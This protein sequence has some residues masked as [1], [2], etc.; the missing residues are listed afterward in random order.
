MKNINKNE[1]SKEKDTSNEE[2]SIE[3]QKIVEEKDSEQQPNKKEKINKT[4]KKVFLCI[5]VL[6]ILFFLSI[7][8]ILAVK[9]IKID[10][11]PNKYLYIFI[12]I[13]AFFNII[14]SL[15]LLAKKIWTKIISIILYI[16]LAIISFFGIKYIS[17]TDSFLDEAFD[18]YTNETSTYYVIVKED[19]NY[20]SL[21]DLTDKEMIYFTFYNDSEKI[22]DLM[23]EKNSNIKLVEYDN[24]S[25]GI[26]DFLG[27]KVASVVIDIGHL[28]IV[29]E[30]FDGFEDKIRVIDTFDITTEIQI[31]DR[32][33]ATPE[34]DE[35]N[36]EKP[37]SNNNNEKPNENKPDNSF[38]TSINKGNSLN[39]Y[40]SGSDSRTYEVYN[41][42][43]TD[44]N[45]VL[46][47][48]P[49]TKTILVTSI[50]RDYYVQ[51]AGTTGSKDK[52]SYTGLYGLNNSTAVIAELFNIDIDY[53]IKLGF[54]AV[55]ELVDLVGGI[56]INSR[57]AFDSSHLKGWHVQQGINHMDGKKALAY[58]RE[59]YAYNMG[60]KDRVLNQQQVFEET[61]KK[62]MSN[63]SI[64]LKYEELL[65]SLK[66]FYIT[67]IPRSVISEYIKLQL[68]DMS[69]WK[70]IKQTIDGEYT[71]STSYTLPDENVIVMERNQA[72]INKARR[73]IKEVLEAR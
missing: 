71:W 19:S 35:Q 29:D 6:I 11:L 9:T 1:K 55:V 60:D 20:K 42:S 40:I 17:K 43:R 10:L 70:I 47:I 58:A 3:L 66:K 8:T 36:N 16:L 28:D 46:S 30:I 44:V 4:N 48:N 68:N 5:K 24:L 37:D 25:T 13:L 57:I 62:V 59:R 38:Y 26:S 23:K 61:I 73:K 2:T 32:K 72:S 41:K 49:N 63:K 33:P 50:P 14:S 69:S 18:N 67:D 53:S 31:I 56:D 15:C 39:I 27:E 7:S 21:S 34:D 65:N 54:N 12:G 51:I 45:M 52:L 22:K 64:L